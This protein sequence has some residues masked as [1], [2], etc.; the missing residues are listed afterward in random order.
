[1]AI[2]MSSFN[3]KKPAG[4]PAGVNRQG[5]GDSATAWNKV[6]QAEQK[7]NPAA[8]RRLLMELLAREPANANAAFKLA[9]IERQLGNLDAAEKLYSELLARFPKN[10]L[11]HHS[12]AMI[13]RAQGRYAEALISSREALKIKPD[14]KA[15]INN[16]G[17]L[18]TDQGRPDE[19]LTCYRYLEALGPENPAELA[20]NMGNAYLSDGQV[21]EAI[22]SYQRAIALDPNHHRAYNNLGLALCHKCRIPESIACQR[23]ALDLHSDYREA[24]SN[25]LFGM[26]YQGKCTP[27]ELHLEAQRW[28]QSHGAHLAPMKPI[29]TR[30]KKSRL[31]I[32]YM[33]PDFKKHPVSFFFL[34]LLEAH[35]RQKF[36]IYCYAEVVRPDQITHKIHSLVDYY[37]STVG[38]SDDRVADQ[39]REDGIDILVDLAGHTAGNRLTVLARKPA[40]IQINWLGYP[41]TTGLATVDYRFTDALADPQG[42]SDR[43]HTETLLRLPHGFLCYQPPDNAPSVNELPAP[44]QGYITFGSF[45]TLPKVNNRVIQIWSQILQKIP[46]ARLMIKARQLDDT[47]VQKELLDKFITCEI[48]APRIMICPPTDTTRD[49]LACYHQVDIALDPFP[50]NGTTTTCEA[51][52]MGV[53][54]ITLQGDRHSGRVGMTILTKVGLTDLIA[55]TEDEYIKAAIQ[56]AR[57]LDARARL[58]SELRSRILT[59]DLCNSEQFANHLEKEYLHIWKNRCQHQHRNNLA[60]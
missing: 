4:S 24:H 30:A 46:R 8:T 47:D 20:F 40:P 55:S 14:F 36:E 2:S 53:P 17:N 41:G 45:N 22:G 9:Q 31:R 28:W 32:G 54:V 34:P 49:H 21:S 11:V 60:E 19:A 50:Y 15:G 5:E 1:M 6:R 25:L 18:L 26:L 3:N 27:K 57:S 42:E 52:Y 59:S 23:K 58:R 7:G 48:D 12:L 38:I 51:L 35:N 10:H 33:S 37:R 39:I 56:M 16:L 43:Y 29:T 13:F 44:D